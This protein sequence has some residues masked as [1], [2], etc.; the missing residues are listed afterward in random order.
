MARLQDRVGS[1]LRP[2]ADVFIESYVCWREAC[3]DVQAAYRRWQ[4]CKPPQRVLA[5]AGYRAALDREEYAAHVHSSS[6]VT[7]QAS[8]R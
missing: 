7:L 1:D 3:R 5:F 6:A 8:A 2:V 4:T